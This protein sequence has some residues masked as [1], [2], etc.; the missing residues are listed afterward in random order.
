MSNIKLVLTDIDGTLVQIAQHTP[1]PA[2]K[3]AILA[4]QKA[5]ITVSAA[6]G[7]PYE[8][9]RGLFIELGLKGLS[10]FDAGASIRDVE[11]GTIAWQEWLDVERLKSMA[12][13]LLP[14]ST[15]VDFFPTYKEVSPAKT[16]IS[17]IIE[18][19]PY[20]FAFVKEAEFPD[21]HKCLQAVP[22]LQIN[23]GPGRAD[24][25]GLV[26]VQITD[27]KATKFHAVTALRKLVHSLKEQTLAIG[28]S[29]NDLPLFDNAGLKIA[30]GNAI[31]E[32]KAI[33]DYVVGLIDEDGFAEAMNHFVL[34]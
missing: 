23:V 28:D 11:T 9:A 7:R 13:I 25:P 29:S 19:A 20:A 22:D 10:I 12:E 24:L 26:D 16:S 6:T 14:H 33:A 31:P 15:V 4:A 1:T 5:G 2:V 34:S 27:I 17:D 8:M 21:V 18:P 32:L 3:E 30:M